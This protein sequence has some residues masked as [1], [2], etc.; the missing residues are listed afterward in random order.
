MD[1]EMEKE[2]TKFIDLVMSRYRAFDFVVYD[3]IK[4]FLLYLEYTEAV[5]DL[6]KEFKQLFDA[7]L[8][9]AIV[10]GR[11]TTFSKAYESLVDGTPLKLSNSNRYSGKHFDFN[12]V[13]GHL[14]EKDETSLKDSVR[15]S[16]SSACGGSSLSR[17]GSSS[18]SISSSCHSSSTSRS[19][20]G[21]SSTSSSSCGSSLSRC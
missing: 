4:D 21:S 13:V 18:P 1:R 8:L 16:A 6:S 20:C 14:Y 9:N 2:M 7:K 15:Y 11:E 19:S 5:E 10:E 12:R 3:K 17:C